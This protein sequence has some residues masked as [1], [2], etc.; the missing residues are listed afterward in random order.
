MERY[1]VCEIQSGTIESEGMP[2]REERLSPH[3]L[4]LHL[5][6][7]RWIIACSIGAIGNQKS[8]NRYN[9]YLRVESHRP[10][11]RI[12]CV[13]RDALVIR[14]R[15]SAAN[16]PQSSDARPAR[17]IGVYGAGIHDQFFL[18]NGPG[19]YNAHVASKDVKQLRQ[20]VQAGLA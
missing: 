13:A 18:G 2:T 20:F 11:A 3:L 8:R 17:Q 12:K 4:A 16:L 7:R 19:S 14:R 1:P 10:I 6:C 5:P 9:Q 15:T